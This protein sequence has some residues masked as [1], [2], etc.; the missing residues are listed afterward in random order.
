MSKDVSAPAEVAPEIGTVC[1]SCGTLGGN[2]RCGDTFHA[3]MGFG[4]EGSAQKGKK[5]TI[6]RAPAPL[7]FR[8]IRT[9]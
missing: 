3:N 9:L 5:R 7:S 4:A 1:R 6:T 2:G 8:T